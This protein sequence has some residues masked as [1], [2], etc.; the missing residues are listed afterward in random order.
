MFYAARCVFFLGGCFGGTIVDPFSLRMFPFE[1]VSAALVLSKKKNA[2]AIYESNNE[3][4]IIANM[5]PDAPHLKSRRLSSPLHITCP[6]LANNLAIFMYSSVLISLRCRSP[7]LCSVEG[8][9]K[10][11]WVVSMWGMLWLPRYSSTRTGLTRWCF[12][13]TT[14]WTREARTWR[15]LLGAISPRISAGIC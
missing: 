8:F 15:D 1:T 9:F 5:Q 11:E 10:K 13:T 2:H 3:Q 7:C 4:Y 12:S 6:A 14:A